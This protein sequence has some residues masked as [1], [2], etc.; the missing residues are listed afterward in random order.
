MR[1]GTR[2]PQVLESLKKL[3]A[4]RPRVLFPAG[5]R[6]RVNPGPELEEKISYLDRLGRRARDLRRRGLSYGAISRKLFGK[7]PAIAWFTLGDFSG[8]HL[9][10]SLVEDR[11]EQE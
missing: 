9:V 11:M 6:I 4:L 7:P 3:A 5:G 10:R 8:R 2:M 1:A